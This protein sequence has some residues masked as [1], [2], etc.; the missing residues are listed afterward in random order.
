MTLS[1]PA[2]MRK[3]EV[4]PHPDE[5]RSATISPLSTSMSSELHGMH[6]WP[7][8][9]AIHLVDTSK[10]E[11]ARVT[12]LRSRGLPPMRQRDPKPGFAVE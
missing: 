10:L 6:R 7:A 12:P 11:H 1:K 2:I 4:L 8:A 9:T 5:P 3:V